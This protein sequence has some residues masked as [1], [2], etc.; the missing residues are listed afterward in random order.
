MSIQ[1]IFR[2]LAIIALTLFTGALCM[3]QVSMG[4]VPKYSSYPEV[5]ESQ[6]PIHVFD[7]PD[8]ELLLED[9]VHRDANGSNL[10]DAVAVPVNLDL[11]NSG[12]WFDLN[13]GGRIWRMTISVPEALSLEA[14]Y[15]QFFIPSGAELFI[16]NEDGTEFFGA[17]TERN[18]KVSGRMATEMVSGSELNFEYFEPED[19]IG[20]GV[21]SILDVAFRYRDVGGDGTGNISG[22]SQECEVDVSCTEGSDWIDQSKSVVRIRTRIDGA[23]YWCTGTIM[24]NTMEDCRPLLLTSLHNAI[25]ESN[26]S[27]ESDLDYFRFYF[28]YEASSCSSG[29]LAQLKTITGCAKLGD[30]NDQG[31]AEGSDYLMLELSSMIPFSYD[32]YYAGWNAESTASV[33][34]GVGIHHPK[35]DLKK[36]STFS[37]TPVSSGWGISDSHWMVNWTATENGHG[38]MENGS[39]GSSLF[40]LHGRVIGTLTGGLSNCNELE[41]GGNLQPEFYGKMSMHWS[42]NPNPQN[43]RLSVILDPAGLNAI[44]F[45]GSS[46]P[47][48]TT[49][50][51]DLLKTQFE[52]FPNPADF[53]VIVRPLGEFKVGRVKIYS[54]SGQLLVDSPVSVT[55]EILLDTSILASGSYVLELSSI[56]GPRSVKRLVINH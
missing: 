30:S 15:D 40:D 27:T 25:E 55:E 8:I 18:N 2:S 11:N 44:V 28:G 14:Y 1:L 45:D 17:Y 32:V 5:D 36:V 7:K 9:D 34:G 33:G 50:N 31:G 49:G 20:T 41:P 6:V 56:D 43:E 24:N 12:A 35:S 19:K 48:E 42:G 29:E 39:D 10:R 16:F 21:I 47:C 23:F 26:M 22:G 3:A 52:L 51:Q 4:G 53:S 37:V 13:S 54:L 38:V 46:N